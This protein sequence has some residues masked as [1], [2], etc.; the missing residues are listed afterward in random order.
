ADVSRF[1]NRDLYFHHAFSFAGAESPA[2]S[3][4]ALH[5]GHLRF[6]V[7]RHLGSADGAARLGLGGGDGR[8]GR[9]SVVGGAT[10]CGNEETGDGEDRNRGAHVRETRTC[11]AGAQSCVRL[12]CVPSTSFRSCSSRPAPPPQHE[13]PWLPLRRL[14]CPSWASRST[15]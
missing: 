3:N 14:R 10:A 6:R 4:L 2:A 15:E 5:R 7:A 11:K 1:G 12:S 13:R 9:R 8:G